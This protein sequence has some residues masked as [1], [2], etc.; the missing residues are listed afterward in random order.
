MAQYEIV[1]PLKNSNLCINYGS[2]YHDQGKPNVKVS[3]VA[4]MVEIFNYSS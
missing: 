1:K 2:F 4:M 3:A